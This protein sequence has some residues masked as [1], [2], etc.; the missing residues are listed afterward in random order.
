MKELFKILFASLMNNR[1]DTLNDMTYNAGAGVLQNAIPTWWTERLRFD[2]IRRAFWGKRFE[3]KE[4]SR[5][6][7]IVNEDFT[8]KPGDT[9]KFNTVSQLFSAG[10]TGEGVLQGNEDQLA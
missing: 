2:A 6:P 5:K 4:G 9:I 1:G 7:I 10:V 3:G 8:K